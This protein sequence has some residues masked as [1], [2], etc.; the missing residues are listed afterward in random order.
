MMSKNTLEATPEDVFSIEQTQETKP[1]L[2]NNR[3]TTPGVKRRIAI[4]RLKNVGIAT[5][6]GALSAETICDIA[7][8]QGIQCFRNQHDA[9][10]AWV[11]IAL[12]TPHFECLGL[13]SKR[14]RRELRTLTIAGTGQKPRKSMLKEAIELLEQEAD[15]GFCILHDAQYL[16]SDDHNK[17]DYFLEMGNGRI[18]VATTTLDMIPDPIVA[19]FGENVFRTRHPVVEEA[20]QYAQACAFKE[21][22]C[23]EPGTLERIV[24]AA[25]HV[26]IACSHSLWSASFEVDRRLTHR[27]LDNYFKN[28]TRRS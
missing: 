1:T 8:R 15:G 27:F 18:V 16:S 5:N 19:R 3:Q 2:K 24:T 17:L 12:P 21:G 14:F 6:Q 11:R 20:V 4:R 28:K 22:L 9:H 25:D 26:P 23:V 13:K 7:L 10:F